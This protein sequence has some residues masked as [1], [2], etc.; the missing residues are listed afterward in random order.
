MFDAFSD[1]KQEILQMPEVEGNP[2][3][4]WSGQNFSDFLRWIGCAF[5]TVLSEKKIIFFSLMQIAAIAIAY[6]LWVQMLGWIPGSVW[7]SED[8]LTNV[9]LNLALLAWSFLCVGLA[10]GPIAIFTGCIGA[11]HFLKRQGFPSTIGSCFRMVLPRAGSLWI[12]YWIDGWFTVNQILERLPKKEHYTN[13]E[14]KIFKELLYYAWKLATVGMLPSLLNGK[15]LGLAARESILLIRHKTKEVMLLRG[16]Y[17]LFCWIVGILTYGG[18]IWMAFQFPSIF[19]ADNFVYAAY[20]WFGIP[21]LIAVTVIQLFLRPIF[22]LGSCEL[23][24]ENVVTEQINP[25]FKTPPSVTYRAF[26][27]FG[28][29]IMILTAVYLYREP[30]GLMSILELRQESNSTRQSNNWDATD[31]TFESREPD[32]EVPLSGSFTGKIKGAGNCAKPRITIVGDQIQEA[33]DD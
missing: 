11:S 28:I 27:G 12:F 29:L 16:G 3:R 30:L 32:H 6:Y 21:I 31:E 23:Y 4:I 24:S 13:S 18:V 20:S 14:G 26:I 10:T 1:V 25:A 33:C 17:S 2:R 7:K 9:G 19:R 8:K 22:V 5:K 15:N